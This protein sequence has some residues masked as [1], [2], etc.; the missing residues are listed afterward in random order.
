MVDRE[1]LPGIPPGSGSFADVRQVA[2]AQ[3]R[4]WQARRFGEAYL[5]GGEEATFV[6][7]VHRVGTALARRTPARAM[8]P[9]P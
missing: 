3:V 9:G 2:R 7:F 8:P 5:L 1:Q 6:D 4:A